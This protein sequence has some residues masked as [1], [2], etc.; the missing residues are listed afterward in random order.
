M[1]KLFAHIFLDFAQI[2]EK[3]KVF[4]VYLRLL[5]P[6]LLHHWS[7]SINLLHCVN[8]NDCLQK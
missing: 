7:G 4:E 2:F 6:Q 8:E 3:S 1:S 5:H